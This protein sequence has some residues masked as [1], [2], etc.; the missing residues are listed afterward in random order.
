MSKNLFN[1][2][3]RVF[4]E[5][6]LSVKSINKAL[7]KNGMLFIYEGIQENMVS[8]NEI[9]KRVEKCGFRFLKDAGRRRGD[10]SDHYLFMFMKNQ[11]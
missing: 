11:I 6:R 3:L 2:I 1:I 10:L 4:K 7:K 9:I 5:L 8:K